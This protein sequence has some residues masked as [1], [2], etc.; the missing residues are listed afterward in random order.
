MRKRIALLLAAIIVLGILYISDVDAGVQ[1]LNLTTQSKTITV[2]KSFQCKLNG[3]KASKVKWSSSK[4]SVATVSKKG[5]VNGVSAGKTV[6]T[7]KYKGIKFKINVKVNSK[8]SDTFYYKDTVTSI[9]TTKIGKY[10][11]KKMWAI[12]FN[13]TNNSNKATTFS[14]CFTYY[15]YINGVEKMCDEVEDTFTG[16]K[17]GAT[18]MPIYGFRVKSGDKVEFQLE[19][20]PGG[21]VVYNNTFIIP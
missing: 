5:V 8:S 7:G 17:D 1:T 21:K 14:D 15:V 18:I 16:V 20:Y 13:F 11:G 19:T 12:A 9:Y 6:I 4:P 10:D 2:G 3:L